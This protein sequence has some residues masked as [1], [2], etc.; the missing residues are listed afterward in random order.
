M[1]VLK[2]VFLHMEKNFFKNVEDRNNQTISL[3]NNQSNINS[4]SFLLSQIILLQLVKIKMIKLML[5]LTIIIILFK[6]IMHL[7]IL[8]LHL[9]QII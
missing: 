2:E 9:N 6:E 7:V 8:I 4:N 1:E 5:I 3:S